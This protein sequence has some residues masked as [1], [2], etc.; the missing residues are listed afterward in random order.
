[1]RF[2]FEGKI[3]LPYYHPLSP[4]CR[5]IGPADAEG[6]GIDSSSRS[7]ALAQALA[8]PSKRRLA[9]WQNKRA[10]ILEFACL[11]RIGGAYSLAL[12][13]TGICTLN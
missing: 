2:R 10:L 4:A 11:L 1:M 9:P 5:R 8:V 6:F 7:I 3:V 13:S 12:Q